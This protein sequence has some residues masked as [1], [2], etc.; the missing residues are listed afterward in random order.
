MG[1]LRC[2]ISLGMRSLELFTAQMTH[3]FS[4]AAC[5]FLLV[6]SSPEISAGVNE[7]TKESL[8]DETGKPK[9]SPVGKVFTGCSAVFVHLFLFQLR[10][11]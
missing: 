10:G 2:V 3:I 4:Y 1:S 6:C 8:R 11:K 5:V 7:V 9:A